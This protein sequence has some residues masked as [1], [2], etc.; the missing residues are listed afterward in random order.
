MTVASVRSLATCAARRLSTAP[1]FTRYWRIRFGKAGVT[2]RFRLRQ[3]RAAALASNGSHQNQLLTPARQLPGSKTHQA[4]GKRGSVRVAT[5]I[6][7]IWQVAGDRRQRI[8]KQRTRRHV[9][10]DAKRVLRSCWQARR[11][12]G[13][14]TQRPDA[15]STLTTPLRVCSSWAQS[16]WCTARCHH[17]RNHGQSGTGDDG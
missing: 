9:A 6:C 10:D 8:D 1:A 12:P 14:T 2:A 17:E 5:G 7:T 4:A 16:C 15:V 13:G 11:R 3:M